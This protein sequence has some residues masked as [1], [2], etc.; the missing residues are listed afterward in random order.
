VASRLSSPL[1][2]GHA[3]GADG[4]RGGWAVVAVDASGEVHW[5]R[6]SSLGPVIDRVTEGG[7]RA[8]LAV[9]MPIGL[10]ASGRRPCDVQARARLGAA[11]SSVFPAPTRTLLAEQ[12]SGHLHAEAVAAA[13]ARGEP[14][15]SLQTWH[16]VPKVA[17]VDGALTP[18]RQAH[19]VECHPEVSFRALD[20]RV[21]ASKAT[22]AGVAQ[23]LEALRSWLGP[24]A[25]ALE[26]LPRGVPLVDALDALVC[27][28]TARRV[29]SG[30]ADRLGSPA[31]RDPRGLRMNIWV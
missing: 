25:A 22:P 21:R 9:D 8:V 18:A 11:R 4:V 28:W 19:V 26:G 30:E 3:W 15:P 6:V 10:V 20:P 16:L 24:P 27:A 1:D 29:F 2:P 23:R 17:Q 7:G 12:A 13:R 14:A 31:D 5:H